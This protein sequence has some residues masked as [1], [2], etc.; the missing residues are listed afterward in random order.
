LNFHK[1]Q[2]QRQTGKDFKMFQT[3]D[4]LLQMQ[5]AALESFKAVAAASFQ[6]FEKLA[7]L[8][9]QASKAT[10]GDITEK[11]DAVIK[12]NDPKVLAE[13]A[14]TSAQPAAEKAGA[15]AKHVYDIAQQ[16]NTEIAAIFEKQ[17][18]ASNK[19]LHSAI[20]AF[21][22]TAPAGSEGVTTFVKSAVSAANT[23]WDQVNKASKQVAD[24]AE[25]NLA[26]VT[27]TAKA[28]KAA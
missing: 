9:M 28:R 21:A 5:K 20:D 15:Y 1:I 4:Q 23:A 11:A 17:I 27:K 18:A 22:K 14:S 8:N 6:G 13:I 3:P 7:T 2:D 24:Y 12:A 25:T 10:F 26:T 16:T 19:Q